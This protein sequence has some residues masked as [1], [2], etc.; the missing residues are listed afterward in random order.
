MM[1]R[2]GFQYRN[3]EEQVQKNKEDIARHYEMSR[4]LQNYGIII[5]GSVDAP[6]QLP[7]PQTYTGSYG[8]AYSVGAAA[9]YSFYV[10]TRPNQAI[11][12][13]ENRWLDLGE[14]A[15]PGPQ[16]P[17]GEQGVQGPQGNSTRWFSQAGRPAGAGYK[18]GDQWL[19][20]QTGDVL[21]YNNNVWTV[22]GN[23]AGAQG[24][25]GPKGNPGPQGPA[26][27]QG[28]Q[29]PSGNPSPVVDILG[30]LSSV[31][32]LP[33]PGTQPTNA[34]FLIP[35]GGVNHLFIIIAGQWTDSGQ[36][37]GG[38]TIT[39]NGQVVSTFN[40]DTKL[41]KAPNQQYLKAYCVGN[42]GTELV[43]VGTS[44]D[45]ILRRTTAGNV[46]LPSSIGSN[47]YYAVHKQY[48]DNLINGLGIKK[49]SRTIWEG[50]TTGGVLNLFGIYDAP[51]FRITYKYN[52][53]YVYNWMATITTTVTYGQ[54]SSGDYLPLDVPLINLAG[55]VYKIGVS[56]EFYADADDVSNPPVRINI[57]VEKMNGGSWSATT[58]LT[59]LKI[60]A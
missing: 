32:Q 46:M 13:T 22:T 52:D 59:I 19:D 30:E 8:D 43:G 16:G 15:I 20:T 40:A 29:G 37:G 38:A 45:Q 14:L 1:T 23:I 57:N 21:Q 28:P 41:D 3:L 18:N 9:P 11:G 50:Q 7:D 53:T 6:E 54:G 4:V 58:D 49:F 33:A 47:M 24:P 39:M 51:P 31:D 2:D 56:Y 5:V 26:G 35:I 48:V 55:E 34:G 17:E 25:T 12:Q 42:N 60:E 36:W 44:A 27:P 10:F